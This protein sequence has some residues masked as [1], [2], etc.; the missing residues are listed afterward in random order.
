MNHEVYQLYRRLRHV[1]AFTMR[2]RRKIAAMLNRELP[3]PKGEPGFT[4]RLKAVWK[5]MGKP[6]QPCLHQ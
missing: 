5:L 1:P 3:P 4:S 6:A 2:V